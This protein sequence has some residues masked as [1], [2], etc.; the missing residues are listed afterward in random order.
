[1]P[2]ELGMVADFAPLFMVGVGLLLLGLA[3][4]TAMH[5]T[6]WVQRK[7]RGAVVQQ[8]HTQA[9][10]GVDLVLACSSHRSGRPAQCVGLRAV[11][12]APL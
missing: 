10:P 1:M 9:A 6:W 11:D 5:D 3:V 12:C 8:D 7:T 4:A 2:N